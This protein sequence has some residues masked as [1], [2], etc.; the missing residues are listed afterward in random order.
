MAFDNQLGK[1]K[2]WRKPYYDCRRFDWTCRAHGSCGYCE[3]RRTFANKRRAPITIKEE[4][5]NIL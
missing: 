3:N 5:D 1:G 2:D 4:Y